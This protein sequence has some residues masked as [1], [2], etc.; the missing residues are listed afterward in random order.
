M[1]GALTAKAPSK[2]GERAERAERAASSAVLAMRRTAARVAAAKPA[3]AAISSATTV[4]VYE[5]LR[6]L[7]KNHPT[8]THAF[9]IPLSAWLALGGIGAGI[10]AMVSKNKT[11][12][13]VADYLVAGGTGAA[14]HVAEDLSHIN[15]PA[16]AA[17][18]WDAGEGL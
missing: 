7:K 1:A 12:E 2:W 5:G 17:G 15:P 18:C 9:G 16:A 6:Y 11:L 8:R 4:G 14:C 10:Y 13:P 3:N